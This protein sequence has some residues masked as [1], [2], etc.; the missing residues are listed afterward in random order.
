MSK[1]TYGSSRQQGVSGKFIVIGIVIV[2]VAVGVYVFSQFRNST[3]G[4]ASGTATGHE[5]VD[6][7]TLRMNLDITRDDVDKPAYCIVTALDESHAEIGR[8]E[9]V[10]AAGGS[11]STRLTVDIPTNSSPVAPDVYGCSTVFPDYLDDTRTTGD[12]KD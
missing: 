9:A 12:A 7:S 3:S 1:A 8:R 4:D 10:V 5:V 2:L 11:E 6:G